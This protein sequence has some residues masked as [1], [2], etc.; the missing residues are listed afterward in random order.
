MK[1]I[2]IINAFWKSASMQEMEA[3]LC[4]AAK[5]MG[6][7]LSVCTNQDF[8]FSMPGHQPILPMEEADFILF[9]D[10]DIRL[11]AQLEAR[12]Y[13]VFNS[14]RSIAL[15]DDKTLTHLALAQ[16]GLPMPE[17][18]LCPSTFPAA[19]YP[20]IDFLRHAAA[21]LSYPLVIKEGCGSFGQQVHLARDEKQALEILQSKAGS[22]LLVQKFIGECAGRDIRLYMVGGKCIAAME[23]RNPS[24]FRANIQNGGSAFPYTPG[25]E[26]IAL[27]ARACDALGLAFAG[28]DILHG[29]HG[30]L[31]CEVNS[32]AHFSALAAL[33]HRD[34]AGAILSYIQEALCGAG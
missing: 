13:K 8:L 6:I 20:Q 30:P 32:N 25:T 29:K 1:G 26:E 2:L 27:A 7:H 16:S 5:G 11:A 19:G 28:V 12:G 22:S 31:L 34:V 9:W 14:A 23:R 15:C 18:I 17:T 21:H 33:T 4:T 10:K 24:D 3:L